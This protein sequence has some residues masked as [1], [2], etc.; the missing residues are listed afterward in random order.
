MVMAWESQPTPC[1]ANPRIKG[2]DEYGVSEQE[3]KYVLLKT[4]FLSQTHFLTDTY[5]DVSYNLTFN[6]KSQ[7]RRG[8]ARS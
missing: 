8:K 4:F 6:S 1:L 2:E 5:H 3:E 7:V